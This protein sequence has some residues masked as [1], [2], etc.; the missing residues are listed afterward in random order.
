FFSCIPRPPL[1]TL[2][3]YTTLFR[4]RRWA[5][6]NLAKIVSQDCSLFVGHVELRHT[7]GECRT[8]SLWVLEELHDP[9]P[10][11]PAAFKGKVGRKRASVPVE[12]VAHIAF[13]SF[14]DFTEP[15][16][17]VKRCLLAGHNEPFHST[18]GGWAGHA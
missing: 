16:C 7:K 9:R 11:G 4:S 3:P 10:P 13:V 8:Q 6:E 14:V 5:L 12:L 18:G 1:S 15:P 17:R 2:F